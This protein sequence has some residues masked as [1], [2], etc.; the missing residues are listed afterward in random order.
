MDTAIGAAIEIEGNLTI[1]VEEIFTITEII[2]PV[3]ET[4][5]DQEIMGMEM[6]IEEIAVCKIIEETIIDKTVVAKGIGI[7]VQVKTAVGLGKDIEATLEI[8]SEIDHLTEVK[9]GIE[10][11]LSVERKDKSS[12]QNLEIGIEKVGL[13]Q[14]LDLAPVLIPAGTDLDALDVVNMTILPENVLKI[15]I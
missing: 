3:I 12:E 8:I 11:G 14:D 4:E 2:G 9:A 10:I 5:V 7:E 15:T 1:K 13:L 6:A